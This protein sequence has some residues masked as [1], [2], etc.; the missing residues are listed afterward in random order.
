[1][2]RLTDAAPPPHNLEAEQAVLGSIL[3]DPTVV[4]RVREL[5]RPED[6][7]NDSHRLIFETIAAMFGG[8][9]RID[10]VT[11]TDRLRD[12]RQLDSAGGAVYVTELLNSVSTAANVESYVRIVLEK[13]LLRRSTEVYASAEHRLRAGEDSDKVAADVRAA[14]EGIAARGG[15]ASGHAGGTDKSG[16]TLA[17]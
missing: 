8:G 12:K 5:L 17:A 9:E 10:L 7:Y 13:S 3:L 2:T 4:S 6:F 14:M 11:V 16:V 15:R 1:P